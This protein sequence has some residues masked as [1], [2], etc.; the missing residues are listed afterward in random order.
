MES[1]LDPD[2]IKFVDEGNNVN[3]LLQNVIDRVQYSQG[4]LAK[5]QDLISKHEAPFDD[6]NHVR[7]F[8][9]SPTNEAEPINL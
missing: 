9:G 4:F 6:T 2:Y 8:K 5:L 3:D 1:N 7:E